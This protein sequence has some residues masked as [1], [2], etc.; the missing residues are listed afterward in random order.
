LDRLKGF[1]SQSS[2]QTEVAQQRKRIAHGFNRGSAFPFGQSP[3]GAKERCVLDARPHPGPLPRGEGEAVRVSRT[4]GRHSC[5]RRPAV[6]RA[7]KRTAIS[8]FRIAGNRRII[9]PL[10]GERA[11]VR[12]VVTTNFPASRN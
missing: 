5:S 6:I 9:L 8:D 10:P 7:G 2:R 3:A 12:A 11:G 1:I 4:R